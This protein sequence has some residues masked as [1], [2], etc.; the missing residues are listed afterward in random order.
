VDP[1]QRAGEWAAA[2]V[3]DGMAV[4]LGTG[5]TAAF[6]IAAVARRVREEGLRLRLIAAS[7]FSTIHL[8]GSLGLTLATL[9]Q[10]DALDLYADGADEVD[11]GK[12]LIK[13]RG[14]A[15][16]REKHLVHL[17]SRFIVLVDPSKIVDRLGTNFPVPVECLPFATGLV[18]KELRAMGA[19]T[20]DLRPA[21]A[22]KDGPVVT[23][24]GN[25]V[26][27]ARFDPS[28]DVAGLDGR[29]AAMPGVV[30]HG[31]FTRYSERITVAVGRAEGVE[32]ID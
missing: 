10:V 21:G 22:S 13:G 17:A 16:V 2:Q 32:V 31:L 15:M 25:F 27:D 12:R 11:P 7:S 3:K 28:G 8:A 30:G 29:I 20:V 18:E 1:K 5:S 6:F 26:L 23:D 9:E 14:A 24:Q 4:G 19:R